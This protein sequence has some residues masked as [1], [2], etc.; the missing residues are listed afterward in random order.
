MV[1]LGIALYFAPCYSLVFPKVT[2]VRLM[3]PSLLLG[4]REWQ[5]YLPFN[6]VF[7]AAYN[8]TVVGPL[9][10]AGPLGAL[11]GATAAASDGQGSRERRKLPPFELACQAQRPGGWMLT[12]AAAPSALHKGR[13]H[14]TIPVPGSPV[15]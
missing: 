4:K 11:G 3:S 14:A 2:Q 10:L 5:A 12:T 1:L 7:K 13:I 6:K 8:T 15:L 9:L